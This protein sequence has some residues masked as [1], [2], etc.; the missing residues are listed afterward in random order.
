MSR[1]DR[2]FRRTPAEPTRLHLKAK[3]RSDDTAEQRAD[4]LLALLGVRWCDDHPHRAAV[5][6]AMV[7]VFTDYLALDRAARGC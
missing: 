5:R 3:L 6:Q 4:N 2:A 1:P 7:D